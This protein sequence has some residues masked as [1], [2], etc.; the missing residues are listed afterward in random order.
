MAQE[1]PCSLGG[2]FSACGRIDD[3]FSFCAVFH[4]LV[5]RIKF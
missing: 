1:S 3:R 5:R 2:C 4:V